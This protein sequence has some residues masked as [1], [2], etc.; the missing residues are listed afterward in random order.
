MTSTIF[1]FLYRNLIFILICVF[2]GGLL[3]IGANRL[4]HKTTYTASIKVMFITN[5]TDS[6]SEG[7][8]ETADVS[9]AKLYLPETSRLI[10]SA[11]FATAATK[12]YQRDYDPNGLINP[13]NI[14]VDYSENILIF[15]ISYT[16]YSETDAINKLKAVEQSAKENLPKSI[17]AKDVTIKATQSED[18]IT[19]GRSRQLAVYVLAGAFIGVVVALIKLFIS[20][21]LDNSIKSKEELEKITGTSLI[22]IIENRE[23][24]IDQK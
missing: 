4:F 5:I 10:K 19:A 6:N 7:H 16:D 17:Q 12:I 14:K 1:G 15:V 21:S 3:G 23:E 20:Y 9:L 22:A 18:S 24:L 11:D 13:K 2:I 8:V